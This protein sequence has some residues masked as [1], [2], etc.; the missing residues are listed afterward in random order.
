M[1]RV[2]DRCYKPANKV[3][4]D[5]IKEYGSQFKIAF[6]ITG[7]AIEQMKLY[8][9]DAL[10]SFEKLAASGSVE[11]LAETFSHSL[12]PIKSKSEFIRQVDQHS[13]LIEDLFGQKPTVFRNTELIYS[14]EI[15]EMVADMGF[16]AML[17]EGAKHILGWRSPNFLYC[18][19]RNPRLKILLKNFVLSDDI[20]FRFSNQGWVD[21]PLTAEKYAGWLNNLDKKDETVNIFMDYE[22]FGE[23]HASETG[24]FEF[25]RN[26]PSAVLKN[27]PYKFHTPSE[28]TDQLQPVGALQVPYPISWADEERDLTAWLGND[29]Q[30][31]A[32][33][34]LYSVAQK[35]E[36]CTD[37]KLL[38]DWNYLQTSDHFY[39]MCTKFFSDGNVHSY[40]NPFDTP[41]DAY[42]N[43]M[44][45]LGDF[46]IRVHATMPSTSTDQ[47]IANLTG[48][49]AE[50][51]KLIDKYEAQLKKLKT[52]GKKKSV[53]ASSLKK[54]SKTPKATPG[55]RKTK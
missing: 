1:H 34:S 3:I 19:S 26:L 36:T 24:I 53:P 22:S 17:T 2:A 42:I 31:D 44:N 50:K 47:E 51:Q 25:L 20:A 39:Y 55:S 54:A 28:I 41:Y 21:Y 35:M 33:N 29:L 27:T 15:G 12:A 23:H 18:N 48:I 38:T 46:L 4:L 30:E 6:S 8:A 7:I 40:F 5:I 37:K 14:D 43:Y 49:L 10:K 32:F 45:V 16:K 13:A 11:F 9:P 52:P